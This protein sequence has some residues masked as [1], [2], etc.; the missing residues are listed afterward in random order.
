MA[1]A[2]LNAWWRWRI[3]WW[4]CPLFVCCWRWSRLQICLTSSLSPD[5]STSPARWPADSTARPTPIRPWRTSSGSRTID[6]S[7]S[8]ERP[9]P[10]ATAAWECRS[11]ARWCSGRL[12][13]LT[14]V[15]TPVHHT[16]GLAKDSHQRHYTFTSKVSPT[17]LYVQSL[18]A[19]AVVCVLL[20]VI[21]VYNH[22][23]WTKYLL[24][25][26]TDSDEL[27]QREIVYILVAIWFLLWTLYRSFFRFLPREIGPRLLL[28]TNRKLHTRFRL[29]PKSMTLDDIERPDRTL[30]QNAC[31]FGANRENFNEDRPIL[32]AAKM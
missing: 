6:R 19:A 16:H 21:C 25:L 17:L 9:G 30:F 14:L 24:K 7:S 11:T 29:V 5:T 26:W 15:Y 10:P 20:S 12:L 13:L 23:L 2:S 4:R 31:V 18:S 32:L 28:M 27:A 8:T 3:R 22:F 1:V